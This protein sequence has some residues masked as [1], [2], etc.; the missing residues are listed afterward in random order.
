MNI[1]RLHYEY[2][3]GG[4]LRALVACEM[5]SNVTKYEYIR[6]FTYPEGDDSAH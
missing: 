6:Y 2:A 5:R 3:V 4:R 1:T